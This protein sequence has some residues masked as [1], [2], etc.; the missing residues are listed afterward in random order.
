M[1]ISKTVTFKVK[2]SAN[3]GTGAPSTQTNSMTIEPD[4]AV[5][6]TIR[7]SST[8][9]TRSGYQFVNWSDGSRRYE[10]NTV[11]SHYFAYTGADQT[12]TLSLVAAW[13]STNS[14]WGTTPSSVS[15]NGSTSYTFNINKTSSVDHH[16]VKFT[17]GTASL[18]YTN[19]G[20]SQTVVFPTSWQEQIPNSTSGSIVCSLTSYNS[21][22]SKI[23]D[24]VTKT[25]TGNVP[26]SVVP[27]LSITHSRVNDNPTVAG[28][29]VLLQ[30][31]SKIA[32][33]ATA[34][35]AGGS[36]IT[37]IAYSGQNLSKT[38]TA[39]TATSDVLNASGSKTWTITA[40]DSRGRT[41]TQTYTETIFAYNAP[42]ISQE[43]AIRCNQNGTI[44]EASG[45]YVLFSA[46]YA[47]LD[48]DGHNTTTQTISYKRSDGSTYTT[49]LNAYTSEAS[50][51]L[52]NGVF[53][54]DK[55]YNIMLTVTDSLGNTASFVVLVQ[56]VKGFALGLKNDRARFGGVPI[57]SGLQID[58]DIWLGDRKIMTSLWSGSWATGDL[59]VSGISAYT[60][61]LVR[62]RNTS[63]S[64]DQATLANVVLH[65]GYFRGTGGYA[66]SAS[67][68]TQYFVAATLSG[69][70]LTMVDCHATTSAGSRVPMTIIE[71]IGVI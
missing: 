34:A 30:G 19:V 63:T 54:T 42:S 26:A 36:T 16:T 8:T 2:Y 5:T 55:A 15:L 9:P 38:G 11:V 37:K 45:V 27:T 12:Y 70:T 18:T 69:D 57:R 68:E 66:V 60:L 4:E 59:Q 49:L 41:A 25:I 10:P 65:G 46:T 39:T 24:V 64:A 21:S 6:L 22:G 48:A 23:G 17:L 3:Q 13:K 61:F 28:W 71:I 50:V 20:T 32:F 53:D 67:S 44:N 58:W 56:S 52:G 43:S 47:Y 35:G 51:V 62:F 7:L 14:T 40:T 1:A 33:T 29:D 31:Y